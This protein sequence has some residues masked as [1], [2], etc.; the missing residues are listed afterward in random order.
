M[1]AL[2][3]TED[4][5]SLSA[6]LRRGRPLRDAMAVV[7]AGPLPDDR[8]GDDLEAVRSSG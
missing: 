2:S 3:N 7:A 8:F 6:R 4:R 1:F 5:P